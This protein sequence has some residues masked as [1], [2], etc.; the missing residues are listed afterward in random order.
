[1][2]KDNVGINVRPDLKDITNTV[3][4]LYELSQYFGKKNNEFGDL[5][6]GNGSDVQ[7]YLSKID[8]KELH[9][10]IFTKQ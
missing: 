2:P 8:D 5:W 6:Y 10:I 3:V 1:M 4:H 7:K 9:Y